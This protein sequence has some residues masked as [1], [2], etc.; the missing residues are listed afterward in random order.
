MS[1]KRQRVLLMWL[2]ACTIIVC[3]GRPALSEVGEV[4]IG[5]QFGLVY[6][7][8]TIADTQGFFAQEASRAGLS[9]FKV[10]ISRFS[11]TPAINDALF[12]GSV[13]L[14]TLGV[15]GLL[16]AWDKT[17]GNLAGLAALG[18]NV[19]VL[20]TNRP[21]LKSFT[22]LT[23]QDRIAVPA[24]TSPQAIMMRIAA[25]K[26]Y[27]PGQYARIDPLLV[28]MPHPEATIALLAGRSVITAYV[29]TP[30][31]IA[32]LRK[33]DKI[34]AVLTSKAILGGEEASGVILSGFKSFIDRNPATSK[35]IIAALE[36]AMDFIARNPEKSA[37]VYLSSEAANMP[38]DDVVG[39]LTDGSVAYSVA[40]T[41]IMQ[42]ARF[43]AK[44]GQ[45]RNEPKSWEEVFSPSLGS[46]HGS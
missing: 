12:S 4:R 29:A 40:P 28:S 27:G 34:H 39:M 38:K 8:V 35:V 7:P 20:E 24:T 41:S 2:L 11:G 5:V 22:E 19:F 32:A 6:L 25:E 23:E 46:R 16:I 1:M 10:N 21:D 13:D 17:R 30:P 18:G 45:M 9:E 44:T 14:G 3:G 33:S 43:M 31:F 36:D 37:D 26:F 42:F 15:P